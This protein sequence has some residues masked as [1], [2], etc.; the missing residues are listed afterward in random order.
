V[1]PVVSSKKLK[2]SLLAPVKVV[3]PSLKLKLKGMTKLTGRFEPSAL[4]KVKEP[5]MALTP[6]GKVPPKTVKGF[7]V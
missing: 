1:E 7:P 3:A 2:G 5:V 4:P 6:E